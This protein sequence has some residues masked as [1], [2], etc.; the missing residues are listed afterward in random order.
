MRPRFTSA[1]VRGLLTLAEQAQAE[2]GRT[3]PERRAPAQRD[4]DRALEYL[5]ATAKHRNIEWEMPA[6]IAQNEA[7]VRSPVV[8]S[9]DPPRERR[10]DVLPEVGTV[11][12]EISGTMRYL[13]RSMTLT[14]THGLV[15]PVRATVTLRCPGGSTKTVDPGQWKRMIVDLQEVPKVTR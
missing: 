13:V 5:T 6:P 12:E 9:E 1:V 14:R 4:R 8:L 7:D 10:G 3:T 2:E 15:P 11:W